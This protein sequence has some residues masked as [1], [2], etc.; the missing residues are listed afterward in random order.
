M[1]SYGNLEFVGKQP[2]SLIGRQD[3]IS[4]VKQKLSKHDVHLLTLIGMAGVGKTRLA[5]AAAK[6]MKADFVQII[7]VDLAVIIETSEVLPAIA[8]SCGVQ[9][10]DPGLLQERL[11]QSIG[12]RR[13]L[14]VVDNCEHVL[15]AM[16]T[17]SY[18]LSS[19]LNLKI[20]ATS[21]EILRLKWEWIFPVAPLPVPDI[22]SPPP[23]DSLASVPSVALFVQRAQAR[24]PDFM[25]T[26]ENAPSVAELC[27][28]LDGLPLAIELAAA[29]TAL[30][31]PK[32][33]L[34]L[35][36]R[37]LY[38]PIGG[39]RDAPA[40][41]QTLHAA[42]D[43]SYDL[44]THNEQLLFQ[45]L[46]VFFDGWTL[47]TIEKI[48]AGDGLEESE[49]ILL[50]RHL[51]DHSLVIASEQTNGEVRYRFLETLHEYAQE[52]LKETGKE[53]YFKGRHL[54]WYMVWAEKNEPNMWGPGMPV[55]L[56]QLDVEFGNI[57]GALQWSLLSPARSTSG[58][59]LF[60]AVVRYVEVRGVYFT[61]GQNMAADFLAVAPEHTVARVRTLVMSVILARNH[62]NLAK[63]LLL[64]EECLALAREL[65]D[66]LAA[67]STLTFLASL[68]QLENDPQ[69][70]IALYKEGVLFARSLAER[71]PRALYITLF[72]LGYCY[73]AQGA[74][75]TAISILEEAML[76]VRRQG[77]PSFQSCILT[78]L[79]LAMLGLGDIEHAESVLLEGL[80]ISQKLDF[81][82][83]IVG[84][85]NYL[86]QAAWQKRDEQRATRILG[87]AA[88]VCSRVGLIN[89]NPDPGHIKIVKELGQEAILSVQ[90]IVRDIPTKELVG[91]ALG[92]EYPTVP[93][94][95]ADNLQVSRPLL[96]LLSPREREIAEKIAIGLSNHDIAAKLYVS[97]RTVDAHVRHIFN[98]L[99]L[100]SRTQ[101]AVWFT[102][103]HNNSSSDV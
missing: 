45:R 96:E 79:G 93:S 75:Q 40:R 46:S 13:I 60:A 61:Y 91:W 22:G 62:G 49:I 59:R 24:K 7:F 101:I 89:W 39:S 15:G 26:L 50:M 72:N 65:D 64:A 38:L 6:E 23:L 97:V 71:E 33:L 87:A 37:R 34:Q 80:H 63:A 77:D 55:W 14:I 85:L 47:Q 2:T 12:A 69:R 21:R 92:S 95:A 86:G 82:E 10:S 9:E 100:T 41:Q 58:I 1:V 3:D 11:A 70:A 43:W 99:G 78:A 51:V 44:L 53:V 74:Y 5:L 81:T 88:V 30:L 84:L 20:L 42:I 36:S 66:Y 52:R 68:S 28:R 102:S 103:N 29:Q 56:A 67:A 54:D 18:L 83:V 4:A 90:K 8:R 16:S 19:C 27:V 76:I 73:C 57:R 31:G 98:K 25:L 94:R 17:L 35:Q 48:C 32:D